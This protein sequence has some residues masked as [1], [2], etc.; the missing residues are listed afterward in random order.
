[1]TKF[2]KYI[3]ERNLNV[4]IYTTTTIE[5]LEQLHTTKIRSNV[6]VLRWLLIEQIPDHVTNLVL[7]D[8]FNDIS[9]ITKTT[10]VNQYNK[11]FVD[12]IPY[13]CEVD[14]PHYKSAAPMKLYYPA[15]VQ[16]YADQQQ[17]EKT[18][19][20][21]MTVLNFEIEDVPLEEID[22][23]VTEQYLDKEIDIALDNEYWYEHYQ[24]KGLPVSYD[25]VLYGDGEDKTLTELR[26][27]HI[28]FKLTKV[29]GRRLT[30][31]LGR[32]II[33]TAIP[34]IITKYQLPNDYNLE[35]I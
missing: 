14:N 20:L 34:K 24:Y 3:T 16:Y 15:V 25:I 32:D 27:K 18:I 7:D 6:S 5:R 31:K 1:M 26:L 2:E 11:K 19:P 9:R 10:V 17:V 29:N 28:L 13:Y 8:I 4:S 33:N 21:D 35:N 30:R 22:H 12:S 23:I